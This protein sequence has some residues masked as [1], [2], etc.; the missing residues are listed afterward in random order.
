MSAETHGEVSESDL[1]KYKALATATGV[2]LKP[3][4]EQLD[5]NFIH[6]LR[7]WAAEQIATSTARI[8]EKVAELHG[9]VG[10]VLPGAGYLSVAAGG[11]HEVLHCSGIPLRYCTGASGGGCSAFLMLAQPDATTLLMAYLLYARSTG[12]TSFGRRLNLCQEA[13][14][15]T[16]WWEKLYREVL[17]DPHVFKRVSNDGGVAV[18]ARPV[19]HALTGKAKG[20]AP[21]MDNYLFFNFGSSE[22]AV[23]AYSATGFLIYSGYRILDDSTGFTSSSGEAVTLPS[24]FCDGGSCAIW[25]R[26]AHSLFYATFFDGVPA[27]LLTRENIEWLFKQGVRDALAL[28]AGDSSPRMRVISPLDDVDSWCEQFAKQPGWLRRG[29]FVDVSQKRVTTADELCL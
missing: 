19:R 21:A 10:V 13:I 23:R 26:A 18:A 9:G 5:I 20:Y 28:L 25:G 3:D 8:A 29:V 27:L 24:K 7:H 6:G 12:R 15:W 16:P 1:A 2:R 14:P 11:L 17:R 22:E 4:E